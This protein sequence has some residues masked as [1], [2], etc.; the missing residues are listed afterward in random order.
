MLTWDSTA[1]KAGNVDKKP[2]VGPNRHSHK[3]QSNQG[4]CG[5]TGDLGN[6]IPALDDV[7][8]RSLHVLRAAPFP[9]RSRGLVK[10]RRID[11]GSCGREPLLV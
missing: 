2:H 8:Q 3:K 6:A 5:F 4:S 7:I 9:P 1:V 10:V 11:T